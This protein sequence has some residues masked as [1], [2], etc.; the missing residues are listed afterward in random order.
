M[1]I[2]EVISVINLNTGKYG[3]EITPYLD[4]F[5]AAILE[6]V[7]KQWFFR[8][9]FKKNFSVNNVFQ[10]KVLKTRYMFIEQDP[11]LSEKLKFKGERKKFFKNC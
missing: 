2:Y 9:V 4:T 8:R 10:L 5:H 1:E 3:P 6:F 11:L 7:S